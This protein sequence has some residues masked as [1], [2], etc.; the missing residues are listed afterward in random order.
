MA[1]VNRHLAIAKK[2]AFGPPDRTA[3]WGHVSPPL[4]A[5]RSGRSGLGEARYAAARC[6]N[7]NTLEQLPILR[8]P[9]LIGA[10]IY[11]SIRTPP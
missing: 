10:G 11:V 1:E 6:C 8:A 9:G 2:A 5:H 7:V 3:Y 4:A